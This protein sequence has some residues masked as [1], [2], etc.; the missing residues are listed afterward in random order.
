[1]EIPNVGKDDFVFY[2]IGTWSERKGMHLTLES[3]LRAFTAEDPVVLVLK[4]GQ[5]DE[6]R[7]QWGRRWSYVMRHI[8]TVE[9]DIARIR[10]RHARPARVALIPDHVSADQIDGLHARGDC[11]VSLTRGEGWGLGGYEAA[12]AGNPVVMTRY[13][14][15]LQYLPE[16]LSYLV[17]FEIIPARPTGAV[18]REV[19]GADH[20]W[21]DPDL[22]HGSRLM[23]HI[24]EHQDEARSRGARLW[25]HIQENFAAD[26]IIGDM[27]QFIDSIPARKCA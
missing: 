11:Y 2:S 27:L 1:M 9:R 21:A 16:H 3:Y 8:D 20:I 18:E 24:F 7:R 13:G 15:P 12:G 23:R 14:G 10:G 22:D 17:D 4:T 5:T 26:A 6:R 25:A 19:Y